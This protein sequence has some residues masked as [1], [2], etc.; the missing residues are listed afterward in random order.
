MKVKLPHIELD[1]VD[2]SKKIVINP[3]DIDFPYLNEI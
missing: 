1:R 3:D 2:Q